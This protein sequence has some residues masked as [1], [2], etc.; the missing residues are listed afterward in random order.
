MSATGLCVK[1]AQIY[2]TKPPF[3]PSISSIE[4]T[5]HCL[6]RTAKA[7]MKAVGI[8]FI[9]EHASYPR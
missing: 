6:T 7:P 2:V 9:L 4:F 5:Q 1:S 8:G 3:Q